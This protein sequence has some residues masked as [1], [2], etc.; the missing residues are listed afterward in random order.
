M[1]ESNTSVKSFAELIPYVSKVK[2]KSEAARSNYPFWNQNENTNLYRDHISIAIF[3]GLIS[4]FSTST[5]LLFVIYAP[6]PYRW[7]SLA[8]LILGQLSCF[9]CYL[10][11]MIFIDDQPNSKIHQLYHQYYID[12][13][14]LLMIGSCCGCLFTPI[15]PIV[16][17]ILHHF[18]YD[19]WKPLITTT[20]PSVAI[21]MFQSYP[22]III[23]TIMITATDYTL[24]INSIITWSFIACALSIIALSIQIASVFEQSTVFIVN[25]IWLLF[26]CVLALCIVSAIMYDHITLTIFYVD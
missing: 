26:D 25:S 10:V 22:Q 23:L 6:A 19:D 16:I 17:P 9:V 18:C 3:I 4:L 8:F 7:I 2:S 12:E 11:S 13:E 20:A 21:S 24:S 15:C 1:S 14:V 5:Q